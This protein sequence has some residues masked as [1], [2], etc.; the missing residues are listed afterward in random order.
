MKVAIELEAFDRAERPRRGLKY[1]RGSNPTDEQ[2]QTFDFKK[3]AEPVQQE[4]KKA[5]S[6]KENSKYG[7]KEKDQKRMT[8][9]FCKDENHLARSCP[10]Q[11]WFICKEL[12]HMTI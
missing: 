4:I 3:L 9:F 11:K 7:L 8:C 5:Y 1:A 6:S 2:T 10:K 12:G